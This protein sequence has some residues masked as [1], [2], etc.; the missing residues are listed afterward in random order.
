MMTFSDAIPVQWWLIDCDTYNEEERYGQ[1]SRC[2]CNP[3]E[4]DDLIPT[5]FTDEAGQNF[6]LLI[7]DDEESLIDSIPI[8]ETE[9]GVYY[10]AFTPSDNTPDFCDKKI[11][12]EIRTEA[13]SQ[14]IS[15][16]ALTSWLTSTDSGS[17][18][19]W[20]LGANPTVSIVGASA[21]SPITTEN[22]YAA[23]AFIDGVNYTISFTFTRITNSGTD[24]PRVATLKITDNSFNVQFSQAESTNEGSNTLELTFTANASSTRIA[25]DYTSGKD[26][27]LTVNSASGT[28]VVGSSQVVAK[29]DCLDVKSEQVGTVLI[30]YSNHRNYAGVINNNG[31]PELIFNLRIPAVFNEERFPETDE[32]MQLSNNR[33]ISLN[34]QVKAQRLLETDQ[35]PNYMRRK[36]ML[37]LKHQFITIEDK[38]YVKEEP[39]EE[40]ENS[41][42]RW[43]MR[44]MTCWLTEKEYV[45]RN[46]L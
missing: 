32:P 22:L 24:N 29:S 6:S 14:A 11:R 42:K 1:N 27:T 45:I 8:E 34:S 3:W 36:L 17:E 38:D 10:V 21:G 13:G 20:S 16:P 25:F 7:Y 46:I 31:S 23:F 35:L 4:C 15:V 26:V 44:R 40:V 41:N 18:P 30:T 5:Q 33:I 12:L 9:D 43:P 2:Y 19:D 39:L 28:R 37:A